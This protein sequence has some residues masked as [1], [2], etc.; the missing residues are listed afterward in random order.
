VNIGAADLML[1]S[2]FLFTFLPENHGM[3][4]Q[5]DGRP[6]KCYVYSGAGPSLFFHG[7]EGE[8]IQ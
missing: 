5:P 3:L 8:L 7:P 2:F 1:L 6:G 4:I